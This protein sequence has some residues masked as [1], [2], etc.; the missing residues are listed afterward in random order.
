MLSPIMTLSK[1][2]LSGKVIEKKNEDVNKGYIIMKGF[3]N[4]GVNETIDFCLQFTS[5]LSA[6]ISNYYY[7]AIYWQDNE[8]LVLGAVDN[9]D[10]DFL[11]KIA[12]GLG[13]PVNYY[14]FYTIKTFF[15][16]PLETS[17]TH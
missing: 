11:E 5:G 9:N 2:A 4:P 15:T 17:I 16:W 12:A 13:L 6:S 7:Y 3:P 14:I 10:A 8:L 1:K